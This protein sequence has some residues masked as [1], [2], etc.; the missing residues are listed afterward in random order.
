M[1]SLRLPL[2][3]PN[4]RAP[5]QI[6][7]DPI[8][9]EPCGSEFPAPFGV[10]VLVPEA[11]LERQ[12][13]PSDKFVSE[14]VQA[15]GAVGCEDSI[16]RCFSFSLRLPNSQ[17]QVEADQFAHRVHASGHE[18]SGLNSP[19]TQSVAINV[20]G[21]IAAH[22]A[23]LILPKHFVA[24]TRVGI[25]IKIANLGK[26]VLSSKYN[27]PLFLSYL[28]KKAHWLDETS[29]SAEWIEGA[30]TP[31]LIDIHPGQRICQPVFVEVPLDIGEYE[32]EFALVLEGVEWYRNS[33]LGTLVHVKADIAPQ[34][35][36]NRL[37]GPA[38]DYA[39]HRSQAIKMFEKWSKKY[40]TTPDPLI[41]ELGGNYST[42]ME[43]FQFK[44]VINVDIDFHGLMSRNIVKHDNITS[45]LADG[46][47]LP[48]SEHCA[49]VIVVFATFH[50][51]PDPVGLLKHFKEKIK[52]G[53]IIC[54]MCEPIGHVAAEHNYLE[55]ISEL[56][57]GVYEQSFEIWEYEAIIKAAGL[58]ILDAVFDRG[59]AMIL[60]SNYRSDAAI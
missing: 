51:F 59:S 33:S 26:C 19:T 35:Y 43:H 60:V 27:P 56:E 49:D 40:V 15:L 17:L 11:K 37:D 1:S 48:V 55:Y 2:I 6:G 3:C 24:G 32:L 41:I 47:N 14:L 10:A 5:I 29:S 57:K 4:C 9:C 38:L 8:S 39:G 50:H 23:A 28:W 20:P 58:N 12:P 36:K 25:N 46:M 21:D 30:R 34:K 13:V 16:R 31:L 18:I 22:L 52:N 42:A 53:G 44:N 54:L 45:I 7:R